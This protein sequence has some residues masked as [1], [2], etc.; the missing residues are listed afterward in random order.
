ME[1]Q[2]EQLTIE[3]LCSATKEFCQSENQL[4][5]P[6][7]VGVTDGKAVG[8][9]V[10][11]RLK[12]YLSKRFIVVVGNSASGIDL[13]SPEINTDIKV[14]SHR[15]PQSSCPYKSSR[16]KI[17]GLGY[18]LLVLV[19]D[20][21]DVDGTSKLR[22]QNCTFVSQECTADFTT[23]KRLAEMLKD[24]AIKE[25]ILSYFMDKNIPGDEITLEQL[26][27][28]VLERGVVQGYLTISNALQWRL[29]YQRVITLSNSVDG[30]VN[31]DYK[32]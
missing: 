6:E 1:T 8:T 10:E 21:K 7:L 9:F 12:N 19:Y 30:V 14:T 22:F 11:H 26:A 24:G 17:F 4:D 28:E 16:Q 29:Q 20:K 18:N 13:P 5:F 27:D 15:Q 23:T 25:D 31:Y 3:L 32:K 2:K